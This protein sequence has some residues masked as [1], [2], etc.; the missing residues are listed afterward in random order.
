M[1]RSVPERGW[2]ARAS[3]TG[4]AWL[5]SARAVRC[6]VKSRNE[7]NPCVLLPM[8]LSGRTAPFNGEEGGDDVKS[9]W[10]LCP[11]L[12]T[13]YNARHKGKQGRE[14]E[15]IPKTGPSSDR[16]LQLAFVKPESLVMAHQLRRREYVPGP[17]THR[18]SHPESWLYPK[19]VVRPPKVWLVIG[20]KS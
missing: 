6:W 20:M 3:G 19:S 12:H 10:P 8:R 11:G 18:P 2:P 14:A 1:P 9:V 16:R 4:A 15:P 7:R 5:S 13:C 17:C